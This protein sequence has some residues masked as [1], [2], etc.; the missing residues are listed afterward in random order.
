MVGGTSTFCCCSL[1]FLFA[2]LAQFTLT[3]D[4]YYI[5]ASTKQSSGPRHF[6]STAPEYY[7]PHTR[8]FS[9]P[10][11]A[12]AEPF[13]PFPFDTQSVPTRVSTTIAPFPSFLVMAHL[14]KIH[15]Q[16]HITRHGIGTSSHLILLRRS[17]SGIKNRRRR[18]AASLGGGGRK[19]ITG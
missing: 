8:R 19:A 12:A 16:V 17:I 15:W 10:P 2:F 18:T 13:H 6:S 1:I 5:T 3:R 4:K 9:P 11:F 14:F 7:L